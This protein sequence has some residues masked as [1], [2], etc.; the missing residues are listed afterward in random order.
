M[1]ITDLNLY[2]PDRK[3]LFTNTISFTGVTTTTTTA[4]PSE[5]SSSNNGKY[6]SILARSNV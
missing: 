5:D 4:K 3:Y 6:I 1:N 2:N